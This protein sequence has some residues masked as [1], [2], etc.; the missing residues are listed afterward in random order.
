MLTL[1]QKAVTYD[2]DRI[3]SCDILED[4]GGGLYK[5]CFHW[6]GGG[7]RVSGKSV[8]TPQQKAEIYDIDRIAS[9]DILEDSGGGGILSY[10][11]LRNRL[12]LTF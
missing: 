6:D 2:I 11:S 5:L 12:Q 8:L 9:C 3:A 7:S 1:R 4:R 10:D